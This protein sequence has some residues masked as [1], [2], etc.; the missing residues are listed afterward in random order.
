MQI[1]HRRP[2]AICP[3]QAAHSTRGRQHKANKHLGAESDGPQHLTTV[4][5]LTDVHR[6]KLGPDAPATCTG[7]RKQTDCGLVCRGLLPCVIRCGFGAFHDG[8]V[9][10]H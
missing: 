10:D 5:G 1:F 7:G 2:H 3:R 9:A 8:P 6:S 4:L